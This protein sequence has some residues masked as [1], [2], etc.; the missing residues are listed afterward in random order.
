[1]LFRGNISADERLEPLADEMEALSSQKR[2]AFVAER[3]A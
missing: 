3:D 1:V 2:L